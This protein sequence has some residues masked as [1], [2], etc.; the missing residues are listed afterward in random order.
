[1]SL[2]LT[3]VAFWLVSLILLSGDIHPNPGP[4]T[5]PSP[6]SSTSSSNISTVAFNSLNLTHNLSIVHYNVQ[7]IFSKIEVLHTELIDFDILTFSETWLSDSVEN[8][9]L[10]LQSFNKPE[11]KDRAGDS[12]GGVMLYVKEGIHYKRRND[13]ELR[14]IESIWIEVANSHKRVLVGLFYRPPNSDA[15]Y[16]SSIEDSVGLAIDTGISDIII[17]GDF[18]LNVNN[19]NTLK[20][21]RDALFSVF[22][23]SAY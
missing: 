13:L 3:I 10:M 7:S 20:Q 1:M 9:D 2:S 15:A 17:T 11:R 23:V 8:D 12:Y 22:S 19:N 16:F 21:N 6:S 5:P 18:N 14:N 4:I